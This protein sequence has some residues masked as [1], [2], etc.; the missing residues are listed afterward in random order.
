MVEITKTQFKLRPFKDS[1]AVAFVAGLNTETIERDTTINLPWILDKAQWWISFIND[2]A[3]HTPISEV[4]FV[5]EINGELA[6]SA[7]IINIDGHKGEIGYWLTDNYSGAGVMTGVVAEVT[8]YGFE[9]LGLTR[10]FAPILPHNKPSARVL[11]KNGFAMEGILRKYYKKKNKFVDAL[12]Y[13]KV[14]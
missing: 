7:G 8:K 3:N 9:Q 4:H 5:I 11:E 12:C 13:A 6:G 1:D 2:A 10:I 14:R